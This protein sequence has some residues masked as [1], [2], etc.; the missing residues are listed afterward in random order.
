MLS[1]CFQREIEKFAKI[2]VSFLTLARIKMCDCQMLLVPQKITV[3]NITGSSIR[4]G[5][6]SS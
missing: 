5:D 2:L 6:D 4:Q 1:F 3:T